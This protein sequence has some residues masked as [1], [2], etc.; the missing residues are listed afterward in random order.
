[1]PP[2][3]EVLEALAACDLIVICP[4][5]PW[6]SID[7]ILSFPEI[8]AL[9]EDKPVVAVSPF[10]GGTAVKGP[11]AKMAAELGLGTDP[12]ALLQHY[13]GLVGALLLDLQ[14]AEQP[15]EPNRQGI[16]SKRSN[17]LM[18]DDRDK[19]MVAVEVLNLGLELVGKCS[20]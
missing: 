11:A 7:P 16:I 9:V 19:R 2:T 14:D 15:S 8:H 6:L 1:V 4:S 13:G 20:K 17:I 10:I 3:P 5:N 18:K 12:Q